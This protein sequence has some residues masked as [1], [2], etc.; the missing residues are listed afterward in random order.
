MSTPNGRER[1]NFGNWVPIRVYTDIREHLPIAVPE[2]AWMRVIHD[3]VRGA[4]AF[5]FNVAWAEGP[6]LHLAVIAGFTGADEEEIDGV[7]EREVVSHRRIPLDTVI[8]VH[9]DL[10]TDEETVE[11]LGG[12]MLENPP[13]MLIQQHMR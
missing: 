13:A 6:V 9:I 11:L 4:P 8:R 10:G 3:P 2:S 12:E 5:H 1:P 7:D